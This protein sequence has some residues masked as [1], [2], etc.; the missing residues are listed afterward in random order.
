MVWNL[1]KF[2]AELKHGLLDCFKSQRQSLMQTYSIIKSHLELV[3]VCYT[4]EIKILPCIFIYLS[5][6][7]LKVLLRSSYNILIQGSAKQRILHLEWFPGQV[8]E[9]LMS[10]GSNLA[11]LKNGISGYYIHHHGNWCSANLNLGDRHKCYSRNI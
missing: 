8:N 9:Q 5:V 7:Y 3:Q 1:F 2:M 6:Q 11:E 4:Y 10:E